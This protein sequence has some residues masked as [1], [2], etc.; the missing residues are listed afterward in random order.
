MF[1]SRNGAKLIEAGL[2]QFI[3]WFYVDREGTK[4]LLVMTSIVRVSKQYD[5]SFGVV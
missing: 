3:S 2:N 4:G 1:Y 5:I